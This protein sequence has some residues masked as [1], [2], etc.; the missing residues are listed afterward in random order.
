MRVG[1]PVLVRPSSALCLDV[2]TSRVTARFLMLILKIGKQGSLGG[3]VP[4]VSDC[5]SGHDLMVW[6]FKPHVGLCADSSV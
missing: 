3:S 1:G 5:G 4:Q 6:E 2:H